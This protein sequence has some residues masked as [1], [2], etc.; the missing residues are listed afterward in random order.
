V[1]SNTAEKPGTEPPKSRR[2]GKRIGAGRKPKATIPAVVVAGLDLVRALATPPPEEIDGF[3]QAE[4]RSS[5]AAMGVQLVHGTSE[6]AKISAAV[7]IL[8]RGYGKP[9]VEIG[10]D[11]AMLPFMTAPAAAAVSS[12][13]EI[14][15]EA[16][17]YAV[18]AIEVLKKIRDNGASENARVSAGR[19]LLN[20]GLGTVGKARMPD[21]L[22]G[23]NGS[24]PVRCG[25][26][27]TSERG[28]GSLIPLGRTDPPLVPGAAVPRPGEGRARDLRRSSHR[29]C[30]RQ[31]ADGRGLPAVVPRVRPPTSSARTTPRPAAA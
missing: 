14:R 8:D 10:G 24:S 28:T 26:W 15:T 22:T 6:A 1:Q 3:A 5:I 13:A 4:A 23:K 11:A 12:S 29:R 20:R 7:E 30:A 25:R 16:R 21:A 17:K 2:G 31:P 18:L 9:A 27:T 19:A